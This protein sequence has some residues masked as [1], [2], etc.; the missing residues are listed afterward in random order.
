[1]QC[2]FESLSRTAN[3][4]Q[5]GQCP[6]HRREQ[7][8]RIPAALADPAGLQ[9]RLRSCDR[10]RRN[11]ETNPRRGLDL[12]DGRARRSGRAEHISSDP[13]HAL[14][15]VL[16]HG[17]AGTACCVP[18]RQPHASPP[19]WEVPRLVPRQRHRLARTEGRTDSSREGFGRAQLGHPWRTLGF[20][21]KQPGA[22]SPKQPWTCHF[23]TELTAT[24][25]HCRTLAWAAAMCLGRRRG[26]RAG[27]MGQRAGVGKQHETSTGPSRTRTRSSA[28]SR[29]A[30]PRTD[31][32]RRA[33]WPSRRR[34]RRSFHSP[35][36]SVSCDELRGVI[37]A[38][39]PGEPRSRRV[40]WSSG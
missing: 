5:V 13:F 14:R 11:P 40:S 35:D 31:P 23:A 36:Q 38:H 17:T 21:P 28:K 2:D 1:M 8:N 34:G 3:S 29:S 25:R 4:R 18:S 10:E 39:W 30:L 33:R 6:R 12:R 7:P 27:P 24:W 15:G 22:A 20:P 16:K 26:S 32:G 19:A 9:A 37:D